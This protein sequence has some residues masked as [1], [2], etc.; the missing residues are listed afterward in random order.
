MRTTSWVLLSLGVAFSTAA[1][2]YAFWSVDFKVLRDAFLR[3]DV[4]VAGLAT[5][6][7]VL[8]VAVRC[9]RWRVIASLPDAT[10]A[11]FWRP[12]VLGYVGNAMFP[13]RAGD[14]LRIAALARSARLPSSRV[15]SVTILDRVWD[16]F[17]FALLGLVAWL[18]LG[19]STRLSSVVTVL[20]FACVA[21]VLILRWAASHPSTLNHFV[22]LA[23]RV[24]PTAWRQSVERTTSN[25]VASLAGA[26][27][28]KSLVAG[29]AFTLTAVA[30][31]Y[32][33]IVLCTTSMG[34]TT[35]PLIAIVWT[36]V[37]IWLASLLP[38]APG[39]VG[40]YQVGS[41]VALT[42]FGVSASDAVGFS[43]VLHLANL[44]VIAALGM[45][46][47]VRFGVDSLRAER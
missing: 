39:Y 34:W 5:I 31:D 9:Q 16:I 46:T 24:L 7:I 12:T 3:A 17:A 36:G 4:F 13:A 22:E 29:F 11:T 26:V 2:V 6:P 27:R 25:V 33:S 20:V 19:A 38:A 37:A 40:V 21:F 14:W 28:V 32:M 44:A 41:V 10:F 43:L 45:W 42:M 47:A 18:S 30:L 15:L 1:L 35:L 23:S 8:S